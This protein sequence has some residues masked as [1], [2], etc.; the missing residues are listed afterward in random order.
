M[1]KPLLTT[2]LILLVCTAS[3]AAEAPPGAVLTVTVA[4]ETANGQS[5]VG[6]EVL[7]H[8]YSDGALAGTRKGQVG[9]D[10]TAVFEDLP[11]G[12][13][14]FA[15]PRARH[16]DMMFAGPITAL[17]PSQ[18]PFAV[19]VAVYDVTFDSS[20]LS[21][22]MHHIMLK[23]Q[24]GTLEVTEFMQL[25][26]SSDMA[27]SSDQRNDHNEP[28]I[29]QIMLPEGFKNLQTT[30][31][32]EQ[33]DLVVTQDGF[34][35]TM[36]VPPGEFPL[37]FSYSLEIDSPTMEIVKPITLPTS[38]LVLFAD[39]GQ[40]KVEGLG[41]PQSMAAGPGGGAMGY[42]KLSNLSP[43]RRVSFRITGLQA[44]V[45]D[46]KTWLVLPLVFAG[47]FVVVILRMRTG[48]T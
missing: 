17:E 31:Y 20:V 16:Q 3:L 9:D 28:I 45:S 42:Y 30:S 24:P 1:R 38:T 7:I 32:F 11:T 33:S 10:G 12:P 43:G 41:E 4:N 6:D 21:V 14:V 40:A 29:V 39:L 18:S 46:S 26:N 25:V 34:Y 27:V 48:K 8:I 44:G 22:G 2:A 15:V 37:N 35:D 13:H 19:R 23:A 5:T 36:A 47:I